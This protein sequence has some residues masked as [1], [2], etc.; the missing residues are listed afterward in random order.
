M[1]QY[2]NLTIAAARK[3][4]GYIPCLQPRWCKYCIHFTC[5]Q[6]TIKTNILLNESSS[7]ARLI[8]LRCGIGG[9]PVRGQSSCDLFELK[10]D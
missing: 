2:N 10:E 9:F 4:Q 3:K 1:E 6:R 5:E 8:N 7:E